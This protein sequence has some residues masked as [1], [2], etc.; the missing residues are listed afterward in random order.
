MS[1]LDPPAAA[2]VEAAQKLL[3][4]LGALDARRA[5]TPLG[6]RLSELPIHPRLGRLLLFGAESGAGEA[7]A[8]VVALLSERDLRSGRSGLEKDRG[9]LSPAAVHGPS[10]VLHLLDLFAEASGARFSRSALQRM[11][12][13]PEVAQSVERARGQLHRSIAGVSAAASNARALTAESPAQ[14]RALLRA[15]LYAYPDRVARRRGKAAGSAPEF[16]L[17]GG[18]SAVLTTGSVVRDAELV[19]LVDAEERDSLPGVGQGPP[20]RTLIR[21]ASAIE[22][23]WLID[24]PGDA[25]HETTSVQWNQDSE[26]VEVVRC[27]KYDQLVLDELRSAGDGQDQEQVSLLHRQ[28]MA[29]GLRVF[30][31]GQEVPRL[32]A[33]LELCAQNG[34]QRNGRPLAPPESTIIEEVVRKLCRGRSSL[35]E[36]R[37]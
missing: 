36:L 19:V 15:I 34:V 8:A 20:A 16:V 21:L 30:A 35:A 11:G 9:G 17:A 14:E 37:A 12:I 22:A 33:K 13:D 3:F 26:R 25:V 29:S 32:L 28:A 4:R 6:R 7:A 5:L 1:F 31:D 24:L 10:D 23:D 27:L 2:S 18:G